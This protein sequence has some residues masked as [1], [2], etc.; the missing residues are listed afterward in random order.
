MYVWTYV[1]VLCTYPLAIDGIWQVAGQQCSRDDSCHDDNDD[2]DDSRYS[3]TTN[4]YVCSPRIRR[5]DDGPEEANVPQQSNGST[6]GSIGSS[7]RSLNE[8]PFDL[9]PLRNQMDSDR[10]H[11]TNHSSIQINSNY[12]R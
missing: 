9:P 3:I 8:T 5:K 12:R 2:N 1:H 10:F 4:H 6:A 7:I 11:V